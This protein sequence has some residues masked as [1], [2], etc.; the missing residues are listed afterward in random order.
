MIPWLNSNFVFPEIDD[1]LS[2]PNGLLAAGGNLT[3]KIIIEAYSQG[4][5]PWYNE[6][7]PIL[8]WSPDP[9]LIL[10]PKDIK[11]SRS[12]KKTLNKENFKV[13]FDKAFGEV[14]S[15]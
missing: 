10:I 5:F 12:L 13:T 1:A 8:W 11:I 6:D 15:Q 3:P 4:I 9:R 7:Q 14:I 2:E